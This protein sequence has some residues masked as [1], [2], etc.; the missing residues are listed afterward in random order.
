VIYVCL[1]AH[2]EVATIGPLLWKLRKVLTDPEFRRDFHVVVFDDASRDGTDESLERYR[3]VLP[4]TVLRSDRPLGYG[5]AVDRMLRHVVEVSPYPKRD[6]AVVLQADFTE[7][8]AAVVDLIKTFEGGA[9]VVA[10]AASDPGE[11]YP[12]GL[13]W[14]RRLAPWVLG[15]AHSRSP[16]ADP[17]CGFRAYRVVVLKK[18][19]RDR[20]SLCDAAEPWVANLETLARTVPHARR[21]EDSPLAL[22]YDRL[23]RPSRFRAVPTLRSLLRVRRAPWWDAPT[24]DVA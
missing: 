23:T 7:D 17:L 5:G 1:P 20:E 15:R 16:V 24:G 18:A 9:D 14:A 22:R 13:R 10:G 2:D 4:L 6:A 12:R 19:L 11:T 3:K 8:P 21:V